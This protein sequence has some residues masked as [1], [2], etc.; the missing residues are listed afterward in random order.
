VQLYYQIAIHGRQDL[1]LAPDEYAGFTMA[2]LRMLA[3]RP[4]GPG[5]QGKAPVRKPAVAPATPAGVVVTQAR[6]AAAVPRQEAVPVRAAKFDGDWPALAR[7]LKVSG[8]AQQLARQSELKQF[9]GNFM[10][11]AIPSSA[12][13]LA[14]K[15]YQDKL[16]SALSEHFGMPVRLDIVM[17]ETRGDSVQDRAVA[18]INQDGFVREMLERF[19]ATIDQASIQ[20]EQNQKRSQT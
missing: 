11:L 16:S 3:F 8:L 13:H 4:G 15:P 17:G 7:Q 1:P 6:P 20:P 14:E 10:Q 9:D 12:R 18:S 5:E 19:D 2:L